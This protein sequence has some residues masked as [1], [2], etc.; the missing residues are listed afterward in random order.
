MALDNIS[1]CFGAIAVFLT[2]IVGPGASGGGLA[3]LMGY[4]NGVHYPK[5]VNFYTL[6]V[7]IFALCFAVSSGLC[8]GKEGPLAHIGAIAGHLTVH[9]PIL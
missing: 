5:F 9:L 3:E 2:L 6:F 7:K 8:I 4:L 1:M